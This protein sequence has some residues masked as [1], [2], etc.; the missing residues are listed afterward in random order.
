[1]VSNLI[2]LFEFNDGRYGDSGK[3]I[4]VIIYQ[5]V[6]IDIDKAFYGV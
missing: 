4:E 2:E 6:I 3:D 1:M 5:I